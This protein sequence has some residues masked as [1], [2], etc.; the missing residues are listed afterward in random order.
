MTVDFALTAATTESRHITI[1]SLISGHART[2]PDRAAFADA[3]HSLSWAEFGAQIEAVAGSLIARGVVPGDRVGLLASNSVWSYTV[4]LAIA[5][6]QAVAVPFSSLLAPQVLGRLAA[7]AKLKLLFVSEDLRNQAE[8]AEILLTCPIVHEVDSTSLL[9]GPPIR[10]ALP[11]LNQP[12]SI[13]YS[14]GTTGEPKGIVHSHLARTC[15]GAELA[16]RF[17]VESDSRVLLTTPPYSNG[18]H[19][20]LLPALYCGASTFAMHGFSVPK[21]CHL[22][23]QEKI[24]HIFMVPTQFQALVDSPLSGETDWSSISALITAGAPMDPTLRERVHQL[25]GA[26]LYELW[27]LT[28][29]VGTTITPAEMRR[30]PGSVGT[31]RPG[32]ELRLIDAHGQDAGR[33]P[34]EIVGRSI[35]VMDGYFNRPQATADVEWIAPDGTRFLRTGDIGEFDEEGYLYIRGREKDMIISGGF[36]IYPIDIEEVLRRHPCI[37]DAAVVGMPHP[38]WGETPVA[39]V[40]LREDAEASDL[41][42]WANEQ[43]SRLQRLHQ[44]TIHEGDFPRNAL[45]KVLKNDL[46]DRLLLEAEDID[47]K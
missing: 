32:S 45:G 13:I 9:G 10:Q 25:F 31:A 36:N 34:G 42:A 28:E 44:V 26:R 29:G 12:F 37:A 21:L 20:C 16:N 4:F 39:W 15:F 19:L 24:T 33:G 11:H 43:L 2:K 14:S 40:V 22:V 23:E 38:K 18:T 17:S 3:R 47:V 35:M 8:Q 46:R 6:A 5:R 30:K 7:D 27:G 1:S 41:L